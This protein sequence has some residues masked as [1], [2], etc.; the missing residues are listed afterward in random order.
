M[1]INV[2]LCTG[3]K[4]QE[5]LIIFSN[6]FKCLYNENNQMIVQKSLGIYLFFMT[7][8]RSREKIIQKTFSIASRK[9]FK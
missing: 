6:E 4:Y 9:N 2:H 8:N 1:L 5:I 7:K 3:R